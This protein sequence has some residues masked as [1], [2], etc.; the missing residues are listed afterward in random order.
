MAFRYLVLVFITCFSCAAIQQDEVF[1]CGVNWVSTAQI[2]GQEAFQQLSHISANSVSIIPFSYGNTR[3]GELT[4]ETSWQWSG[5]SFE[6]SKELISLAKNTG[7]KVMLKPQVW[8]DHGTFTGDVALDSEE[9]WLRFEKSY[10][11]YILRH[12]ENAASTNAEILCIG[13][14]LGKFVENRPQFWTQ[15]I[16]KIRNVFPGKLTYAANWDNYARIPF[17]DSLDFIGIDAY[18]PLTES[19]TPSSQEIAEVWEKHAAEIEKVS[20]LQ[21]KKVLFCEYGFRSMTRTASRPWESS[22]GGKIDLEGQKNAYEGTFQSIWK[23]DFM[24]GG[25]LWKWY[26]D[27]EK[28]GGKENNRFTPQNKPAQATIKQYYSSSLR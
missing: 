9:K 11:Y 16:Q 12:A 17:W 25:F 13:T 23:K 1:Y 10:E 19:A 3:T 6:G 24:A 14:E 5:E 21:D 15:L 27:H 4:T 20:K 7:L 28:A 18:F 8:F 22:R 2:P 26:P